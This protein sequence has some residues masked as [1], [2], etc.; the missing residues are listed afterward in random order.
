MNL[1]SNVHSDSTA[2]CYTSQAGT[3]L[4]HHAARFKCGR[5]GSLVLR[6]PILRVH[7]VCG[8]A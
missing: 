5:L 7:N 1:Y 2:M 4:T 8:V 3:A 6:L